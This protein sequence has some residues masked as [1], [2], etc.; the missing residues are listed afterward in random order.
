VPTRCL[1]PAGSH[2]LPVRGVR[3]LRTADGSVQIYAFLI[4][5]PKNEYNAIIWLD[6]VTS[7]QYLRLPPGVV[8]N[9]EGTASMLE[10]LLTG[11]VLNRERTRPHAGMNSVPGWQGAD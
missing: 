9:M 11:I 4:N 8:I 10:S 1:V 3:L 2:P 5:K 7:P 6:R